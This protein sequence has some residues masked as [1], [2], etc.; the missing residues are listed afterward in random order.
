MQDFVGV[1]YVACF[2]RTVQSPG[3]WVHGESLRGRSRYCT[4]GQT[5]WS[6]GVEGGAGEGE[7]WGVSGERVENSSVGVGSHGQ[8]TEM[9]LELPV[10]TGH[11][12]AAMRRQVSCY[13][14]AE[15]YCTLLFSLIRALVSFI[16]TALFFSVLNFH[17][18]PLGTIRYRLHVFFIFLDS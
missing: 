5:D 3:G 13:S 12:M 4:N 11:E 15:L 10:L 18:F 2:G 16:F 8:E 1:A 9:G 14:D 7:S 6:T 17:C